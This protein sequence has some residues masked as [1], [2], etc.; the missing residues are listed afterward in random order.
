MVDMDGNCEIS[1]MGLSPSGAKSKLR[2]NEF[3][4][5]TPTESS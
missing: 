1:D 2:R 3:I 5:G 4:G